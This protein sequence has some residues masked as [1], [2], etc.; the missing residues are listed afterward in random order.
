MLRHRPRHLKLDRLLIGLTRAVRPH[1]GC[2][3]LRS[4]DIGSSA[5]CGSEWVCLVYLNWFQFVFA[6][7][8]LKFIV[9]LD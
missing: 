1:P 2:H 8:R 6:Q 3:T 4:S 5:L 9:E 7:V